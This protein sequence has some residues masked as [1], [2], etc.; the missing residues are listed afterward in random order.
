MKVYI[1]ESY[2]DD[3]HGAHQIVGVYASKE[4]AEAEKDRLNEKAECPC[5]PEHPDCDFTY[6]YTVSEETVIPCGKEGTDD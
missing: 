5:H 4:E 3:Y 2:G 1:L 6:W